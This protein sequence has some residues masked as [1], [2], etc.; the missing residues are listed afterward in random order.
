MS[1]KNIALATALVSAFSSAHAVVGAPNTSGDIIIKGTVGAICEI[2]VTDYGTN[3]NLVD[4]ETA[5]PV[6]QI[7]ETCNNPEGYA[8]EIS[9]ANGSVMEGPLGKTSAYTV[10]YD[11][12]ADT[13]LADAARL[14]RLQP[15]WNASYEMSVNV[16][17]DDE[18]PAGEYRDVVTVTIAAL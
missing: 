4:G 16:T 10:N 13:N 17:G 5:T 18:L 7:K 2:G 3:L 1:I 12:L 8:V 11:S 9:S 14:E 6:G 15:Q